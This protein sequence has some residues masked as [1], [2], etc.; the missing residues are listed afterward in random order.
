MEAGCI[1]AGH[2]AGTD[3]EPQLLSEISSCL[4]ESSRVEIQA[5]LTG[6]RAKIDVN[7]CTEAV[8]GRRLRFLLALEAPEGVAD[9][10]EVEADA[11]LKQARSHSAPISQQMTCSTLRRLMAV[12]AAQSFARPG[13]GVS[14]GPEDGQSGPHEKNKSASYPSPRPHL[15]GLSGA[16]STAT[17]NPA[18][19]RSSQVTSRPSRTSTD[20]SNFRCCDAHGYRPRWRT[21]K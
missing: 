17:Q 13:L 11:T 21:S 16:N 4:P 12:R 20:Q 6:Q 2:P 1:I 7:R 18:D 8:P 19:W 5:V 15:G 14:A 10:L 3:Q 9:V